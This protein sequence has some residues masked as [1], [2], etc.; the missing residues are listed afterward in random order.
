MSRVNLLQKLAIAFGALM[1]AVIVI[2]APWTDVV[3]G[4]PAVLIGAWAPLWSPPS[5]TAVIDA[6]R[7]AIEGLLVFAV[8]GI[9]LWMMRD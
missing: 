1:L 2:M 9:A 6:L 7:L 3:A 4:E 8:T 5:E